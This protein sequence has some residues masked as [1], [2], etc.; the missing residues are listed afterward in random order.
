MPVPIWE[1]KCG[2]VVP[3][4]NKLM[5]QGTAELSEWMKPTKVFPDL[6]AVSNPSSGGP[7]DA[8]RTPVEEWRSPGLSL[9]LRSS[10]GP[11]RT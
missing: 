4:V 10:S 1:L 11:R 9:P 8:A 6:H 2:A 5:L 3:S 7:G